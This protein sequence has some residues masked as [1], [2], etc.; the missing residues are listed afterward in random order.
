MD[1]SITQ[2]CGH[3]DKMTVQLSEV[4]AFTCTAGPAI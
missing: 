3:R 2:T 1:K 4:A